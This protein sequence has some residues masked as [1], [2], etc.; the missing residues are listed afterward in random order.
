MQRIMFDPN[1]SQYFI[2]YILHDEAMRTVMVGNF[3]A[4][5]DYYHLI[6]CLEVRE[7][8]RYTKETG[9]IIVGYP[10]GGFY[11]CC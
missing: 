3:Q 4:V 8:R 7:A 2:A 6:N 11:K 5:E 9:D 1:S 10:L